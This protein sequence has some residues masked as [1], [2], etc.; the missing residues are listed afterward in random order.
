MPNFSI[1]T[2]DLNTI[3]SSSYFIFFYLTETVPMDLVSLSFWFS[4]NAVLS[5][6]NRRQAFLTNNVVARIFLVEKSLN[7][8][9]CVNLNNNTSIIIFFYFRTCFQVDKYI[10]CNSCGT[11]LAQYDSLFAMSKEGVQTSYC[12]SGEIW[13]EQSSQT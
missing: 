4:Q 1:K 9:F 13:N 5:T 11:K 10:V 6:A 12:N 8:C 3:Y 7:V 2:I